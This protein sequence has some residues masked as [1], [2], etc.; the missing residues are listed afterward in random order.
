[1]QLVQ[2]VRNVLIKLVVVHV[3]LDTKAPTVILPVVAMQL[4]QAVCNVLIQLAN[5]PVMLDTK[6]P[7]VI[8]PMLVT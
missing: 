1:M 4:V 3:M 5:V 7:N 6:A 8:L 2:A